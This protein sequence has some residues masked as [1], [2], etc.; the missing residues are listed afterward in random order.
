MGKAQR[1]NLAA[2]RIVDLEYRI[3]C[4]QRFHDPSKN[5]A[6]YVS[7]FF[8]ARNACRRCSARRLREIRVRSDGSRAIR[9]RAGTIISCAIRAAPPRSAQLPARTA[10]PRDGTR[11]DRVHA[12]H[13]GERARLAHRV[14]H[15]RM[16]ASG[17]HHQPLA[18]AGSPPA[19][20]RRGDRDR[21]AIAC[22]YARSGSESRSR[23]RSSMD[24]AGDHHEV[25]EQ[26]LMAAFLD[27]F[28]APSWRSTRGRVAAVA[29][30]PVGQ[31][32]PC[33]GAARRDAAAAACGVRPAA[34]ASRPA[35]W[36]GRRGR[37]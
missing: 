14:D 35:R 31:H 25:A 22:R 1:R 3:P 7:T 27:Q 34:A 24:S 4:R 32:A 29:S 12:L 6:S 26:V 2:C 36:C 11:H 33:A 13:A 19:P 21:P 37:G 15:A 18:G 10:F 8:T 28:D 23:S 20:G 16:T 17:Q 9:E 30:A 5:V